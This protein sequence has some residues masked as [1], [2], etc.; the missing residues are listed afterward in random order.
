MGP[1]RLWKAK[2]ILVAYTTVY[3]ISVTSDLQHG[4]MYTYWCS[5]II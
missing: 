1:S 5:D 2:V 3:D 4:Q